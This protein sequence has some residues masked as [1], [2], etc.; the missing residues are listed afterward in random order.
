MNGIDLP[1]G[2]VT[3]VVKNSPAYEAGIM[4]GDEIIAVNG[5]SFTV[6]GNR[7][8]DFETIFQ[9]SLLSS[10]DPIV[11]TVRREDDTEV[12]ITLIP[13]KQAGS[14]KKLRFSGLEKPHEPVVEPAL[15]KFPEVAKQL[16]D[17]TGLC[18]GDVIKA[19]NGK[20]VKSAWDY[21]KLISEVFTPEVELTVSRQWPPQPDSSER[22]TETV[23]LP[24]QISAALTNF[25]NEYDMTH[26]CSLVPRLK[27]ADDGQK[28]D[29][30]RS[31]REKFV[32]WI[33]T[34]V[35]RKPPKVMP[36]RNEDIIVKVGDVDYPNYKQLREL[37]IQYEDKDMP[38]TVLRKDEQGQ[39]KRVELMLYPQK[40][41]IT[42]RVAVGF[43]PGL[44]MQHPVVAQVIPDT[45]H[46]TLLSEIPAGATI[47]TVDGEPVRNFYDIA[48]LLQK[49]AG[50]KVSIEY[51]HG[52][53]KG[54]TAVM[55]PGIEPV[56]AESFM[57]YD[58]P[59]AELTSEFK[60]SGP[61]QAVDMGFKKVK[62][63]IV[64]NY[65]TLLQLFRRDG[66]E[67]S[68]LSGPVGIIKMTYQVTA[69][70][71]DR[72]LYFLG[73]ISSCLAVM[74]LLPLPV[75]D[76]GHIVLLV[77]EKITGKPVHEKILAPIM[78]I[79]LALLLTLVLFVTFYDLRRIWY[80]I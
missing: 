11:Y 34:T 39:E 5:E 51:A 63:F 60:A 21:E 10:G 37:T 36:L 26:F 17:K 32:A 45:G 31:R 71:V 9:T 56:H 64:T 53:R 8:V 18:P 13:E 49:N 48:T 29:A 16:K 77:I 23:K 72:Y 27:V 41:P 3:D 57:V 22:T 6:N 44:D 15:A 28:S 58:I 62:Q 46:S 61:L 4:P 54:V 38:V 75:L 79:G 73:L 14:K 12:D 74:N 40:N 66:V 78:Y 65:V 76:G 43:V 50:Q 80:G 24:M 2:R 70:S 67:V 7:R 20:P 59:Y 55:V 52:D 30:E 47:V 1:S 42:K 35:L 19:V 69:A 68:D 33:K 25:R